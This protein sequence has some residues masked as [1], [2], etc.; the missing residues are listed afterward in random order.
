MKDK[1]KIIWKIV[2]YLL[3][4][5]HLGTLLFFIFGQKSLFGF[6]LLFPI[7]NTILTLSK[8]KK[9]LFACNL[10]MFALALILMVLRINSVLI[11]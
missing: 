1:N 7:P 4:L 5:I 3:T 8:D 2:L 10:I 9:I 11:K 6:N